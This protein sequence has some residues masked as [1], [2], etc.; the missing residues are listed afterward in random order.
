[1]PG[2]GPSGASAAVPAPDADG[3][4]GESGP[5][6]IMPDEPVRLPRYV[7]YPAMVNQEVA[8]VL[9]AVDH[10]VDNNRRSVRGLFDLG[11]YR[12]ELWVRIEWDVDDLLAM[13]S[14]QM[15]AFQCPSIENPTRLWSMRNQVMHLRC[16]GTN[17]ALWLMMRFDAICT[18]FRLNV[19]V[20]WI[21]HPSAL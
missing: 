14:Q 19:K 10:A 11:A 9:F 8:P 1:M 16:F 12:R 5:L 3:P 7:E 2:V 4:E 18:Q 17:K 15:L 20:E 13:S 6:P 21:F